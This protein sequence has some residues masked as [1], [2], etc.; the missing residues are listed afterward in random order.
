MCLWKVPSTQ[1]KGFKYLSHWPASSKSS[2]L[3]PQ[4]E[5]R[6][7]FPPTQKG[8]PK[9][10]SELN[11]LWTCFHCH[12]PQ[13]IAK[14]GSKCQ[15]EGHAKKGGDRED[16][17]IIDF[18]LSLSNSKPVD[19]V[20]TPPSLLWPISDFLSRK[21]GSWHVDAEMSQQNLSNGFK[22]LP[23]GTTT[24]CNLTMVFSK[25]KANSSTSILG[26]HVGFQGCCIWGDP[27]S[28]STL[29]TSSLLAMKHLKVR[30]HAQQVKPVVN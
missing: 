16:M 8:V 4:L 28:K 15:G 7:H 9:G 23:A 25:G 3:I 14:G 12:P 6:S 27:D 13:E 17:E 22:W 24:G 26:F 2:K 19:W 21:N 30:F 29:H 20:D 18:M 11:G 5:V 1:Q 10:S